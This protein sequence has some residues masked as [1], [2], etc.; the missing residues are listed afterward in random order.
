[1]PFKID[2]LE[3]QGFTLIEVLGALA[4]L[5]LLSASIIIMFTTSGM[6]ILHAGRQN[7]A[8]DYAT[9]LIEIIKAHSSDLAES[10]PDFEVTDSDKSDQL[11]SLVLAPGKPSIQVEAPPEME[12]TVTIVRYDETI[13]YDSN[14]DGNEDININFKDNLFQVTV[15]INWVERGHD[16]SLQMVTIVGAK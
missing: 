14:G 10:P 4:V 9:S 2:N 3:Q 12:A 1:M 15:A 5:A 8:G 11:F 13:F 16:K 7:I 6:W